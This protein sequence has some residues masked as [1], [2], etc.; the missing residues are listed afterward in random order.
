[1]AVAN[2]TFKKLFKMKAPYTLSASTIWK[3]GKLCKK[4]EVADAIMASV[5][6]E[7]VSG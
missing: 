1:M 2:F 5:S 6:E 3:E 4:I 7:T